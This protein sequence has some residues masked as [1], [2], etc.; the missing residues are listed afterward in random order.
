MRLQQ[1]S[2][3]LVLSKQQIHFAILYKRA[4]CSTPFVSVGSGIASINKELQNMRNDLTSLIAPLIYSTIVA[5]LG[6]ALILQL[7]RL[8][9]LFQNL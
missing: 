5:T 9:G 3:H 2:R 8:T 6:Y 1:I 7:T 4:V